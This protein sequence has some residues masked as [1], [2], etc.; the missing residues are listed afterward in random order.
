MHAVALGPQE[1]A[2]ALAA[3]RDWH[4]FPFLLHL[5]LTF[6]PEPHL[7]KLSRKLN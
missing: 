7:I 3:G 1:P 6:L 2:V 5:D 4:S